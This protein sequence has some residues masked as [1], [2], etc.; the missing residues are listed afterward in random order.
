MTSLK[1]RVHWGSAWQ[2]HSSFDE[3]LKEGLYPPGWGIKEAATSREWTRNRKV[4][5][6]PL[7]PLYATSWNIVFLIS[8]LNSSFQSEM[9]KLLFPSLQRFIA[10]SLLTKVRIKKILFTTSFTAWQEIINL[11]KWEE[12]RQSQTIR[13]GGTESHGSVSV[14]SRGINVTASKQTAELPKDGS[15]AARLFCWLLFLICNFFA[16]GL[17]LWSELRNGFCKSIPYETPWG[18]HC[19]HGAK[20][21]MRR[22]LLNPVV[23]G[24]QLKSDASAKKKNTAEA[25]RREVHGK[26]HSSKRGKAIGCEWEAKYR[27]TGYS[28]GWRFLVVETF[29]SNNTRSF[30]CSVCVRLGDEDRLVLEGLGETV[31]RVDARW[32]CVKRMS[33]CEDDMVEVQ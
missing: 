4:H 32:K 25:Q 17:S 5:P 9:D 31:I 11:V 33:F 6:L 12:F 15:L 22:H 2:P 19:P 30:R 13:E 20:N 10:L 8:F 23:V 29:L 21:W 18:C 14:R 1:N 27:A 3:M 16:W 7:D 24:M 28:E 26:C